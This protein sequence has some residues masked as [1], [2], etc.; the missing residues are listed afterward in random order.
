MTKL[1]RPYQERVM[2]LG[3]RALE[4]HGA[5]PVHAEVKHERFC[6]MS[7]SGTVCVCSP[8]IQIVDAISNKILVE[9]KGR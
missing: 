3:R 5:R 1:R 4:E 6:P 9:E 7:K 2:A 8:D